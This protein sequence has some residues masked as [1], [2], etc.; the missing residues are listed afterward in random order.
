MLEGLIGG[1]GFFGRHPRRIGTQIFGIPRRHLCED[2]ILFTGCC[3][4]GRRGGGVG[5]AAGSLQGVPH[6]LPAV[7]RLLQGGLEGFVR[8]GG[9]FG[10]HAGCIGAECAAVV[11]A[12][13]EGREKRVCVGLVSLLFGGDKRACFG[14]LVGLFQCVA[15]A[16]TVAEGLHQGFLECSTGITITI[17]L[18]SADGLV[19]AL[20]GGQSC[21]QRIA[22]FSIGKLRI[23]LVLSGLGFLS[24]GQGFTDIG[25]AIQRRL[26]CFFEGL[27]VF[28]DGFVNVF[29]G[30][31]GIGDGRI[32]FAGL[33]LL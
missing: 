11:V 22:R 7:E 9:S 5:R 31:E 26:Q 17:A 21:D 27:R 25:A 2:G 4:G 24:L 29:T 28:A 8:G 33:L 15:D 12:G 32:L 10:G 16:A 30:S 13:C 23:D 6:G 18:Q 19:H 14:G 3:F 1:G 20:A